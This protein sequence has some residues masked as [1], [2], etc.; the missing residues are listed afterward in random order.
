MNP[1]LNA[2]GLERDKADRFSAITHLD[3]NLFVEAGAG[4]GKTF[5]LVQ[6]ILRMICTD[7][8]KIEQLVA[9]TFTETAAAELKSR[10]RDGLASAAA[11]E[12]VGRDEYLLA[13][14]PEIVELAKAALR[15]VDSA[16]ITT[17]HSLCH[18]ILKE[19]PVE[20]GLDPACSMMDAIES[21]L[22][23]DD[24][25]ESWLRRAMDGT[26]EALRLA[27]DIGIT[28]NQLNELAKLMYH[29][30]DIVASGDY[31]TTQSKDLAGP[32][33]AEECISELFRHATELVAF[34]NDNCTNDQDKGYLHI[35]ESL[36]RIQDI[37]GM[38]D[39]ERALWLF[40]DLAYDKKMRGA[41]GNWVGETV[42]EQRERFKVLPQ[43]LEA[44]RTH[45][46]AEYAVKIIDFIKD[47][48]LTYI[49]DQKSN[50]Q[51]LD[52]QDL[53]IGTRNLLK[54]KKAVRGYFQKKYSAILLDEFQDTDP[55]QAEIAFYLAESNPIAD[56]WTDVK[57]DGGRLF[58][59]GDPKQSIY[60]FR[61]ADIELFEKVRGLVIAGDREADLKITKNF[62]SVSGVIDWVNTAFDEVMIESEEGSYQPKYEPLFAAEEGS[63]DLQQ[64]S[65]A[66]IQS[67]APS[68]GED[69]SIGN[70]RQIE[71]RKVA[72]SIHRLK[73]D[74]YKIRKS[75]SKAD[76]GTEWVPADYGDFA[77]LMPTF[78]S[79]DLYQTALEELHIPY[80]IE[81]G[82]NYYQKEEVRVLSAA[83]SAIADPADK[84][85]LV[86]TARSFL[87]GVS[88]DEL[89]SWSAEGNLNYIYPGDEAKIDD[90]P[91]VKHC[92]DV[93]TN[94]NEK[95]LKV[96]RN[97]VVEL[98]IEETGAL[99]IASTRSGG[100]QRAQNLR[101]IVDVAGHQAATGT[102]SLKEF[103]YWL[104]HMD[105][106]KGKEAES[107]GVDEKT[108]QVTILSIH[109]SKGL[110][111]PIVMLANTAKAGSNSG[112]CLIV[113]R[114]NERFELSV[115]AAGCASGYVRTG[116]F[117][118]FSEMEAERV[119]A[120]KIRLAY[121]AATRAR[122]LLVI[123][124]QNKYG[125]K[126]PGEDGFRAFF[127]PDF[128][129]SS[130]SMERDDTENTFFD[131]RSS[132]GTAE[133][134]S[135]DIEKEMQRRSEW[136]ENRAVRVEAASRVT[137]T[138]ASKIKAEKYQQEGDKPTT[139]TVWEKGQENI[140]ATDFGKLFHKV[141]EAVEFNSDGDTARALA[142]AHAETAGLSD[143]G[144]RHL[145]MLVSS[146][147]D[148]N[149][150]RRARKADRVWREIPF[151]VKLPGEIADH[152]MSTDEI[153]LA[154]A[155]GDNLILFEGVI[156]LLFEEEGQL[157]IV[158]Y[159][160]DKVT[161]ETAADQ[162]EEY[163]PQ[164]RIYSA[165][166]AISTGMT[167]KDSEILM[168]DSRS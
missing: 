79:V 9:I 46:G 43:T 129:R 102:G 124:E 92:F 120:E 85:A 53:L 23:F 27:L 75:S 40:K 7:H 66:F 163:R 150:I 42:K 62:R 16:H 60:R 130:G 112:D 13:S 134:K 36:Q 33:S 67:T 94:L 88:D 165:A 110:E 50:Y 22:F 25:W 38:D 59:V 51:I 49:D 77:I 155:S 114:E 29:N 122:D 156:D 81:G 10:V 95:A 93:L 139:V 31:M 26:S 84:I 20:A 90:H 137:A 132:L 147:L 145:W 52:F 28:L 133:T 73:A 104:R 168:A 140:S 158:D 128:P 164:I 149:V 24:V 15:G 45:I 121:V 107:V 91:A 72:S 131:I 1:T 148:D 89:A 105:V 99:H 55:L 19:R 34:A 126:N 63:S 142:N 152:E 44:Y 56:S 97:L 11:G 151:S 48:F 127:N 98:L 146:C 17:I 119:A 111:Y 6:R 57:I 96:P 162:A 117:C 2:T 103:A 12:S 74:G 100:D 86:A 54:D 5:T 65:V 4:T 80:R 166:A 69:L 71:A 18:S 76:Q 109:K 123:S 135:V 83:L 30:R 118:R 167:V 64:P 14:T 87:F 157:V 154:L 115:T 41:K 141:M 78:S 8:I 116:D 37:K 3:R 58:V 39:T 70:A 143:V 101:K 35:L 136:I 108:P 47:E 153:N 161:R 125:T 106:N 159:K 144:A 138:S 61:R 160:S 113:D 32:S 82:K 21:S 68:E